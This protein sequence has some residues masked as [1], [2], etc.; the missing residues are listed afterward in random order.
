[1]FNIMKVLKFG[2]SSVANAENIKKV[3]DII[4]NSIKKDK[5]SIVVVSALGGVTDNLI[6]LAHLASKGDR[7]YRKLMK[8]IFEQ[9]DFVV[10]KLVSKKIQSLIL[11]KIKEKYDEL[12]DALRG[13][14]LLGELSARSLDKIISYGEQLSS[15]IICEAI[16]DKGIDCNF[17]DARELIK[18]D[19]NFGSAQ[20]DIEKTCKLLSGYFKKYNGLSIMGGFISS[21]TD[22]IT[23]TLGRGGSDYTASLVGAALDAHI[24]EIWT[25]VD[26]VLTADP[27][28][29]PHAFLLAQISYEEAG[30][31]AHF[32]AK[33]IHP[34]T[35]KP[36]RFKGIP[37]DI[38]NTFNPTA[39]GTRICKDTLKQNFAIRAISSLSNVSLL[40]IQSNNGRVIGEIAAKIFHSLSRSDVEILLITQASH[41]QSLSIAVPEDQVQRAKEGIEREFELELQAKYISPISIKNKLSIV[42]IVGRHMQGVPGISGKLFS[43]LGKSDINVV[44]I[45]QGSSE[46]NISIVIDSQDEKKALGEIHKAFFETQDNSIHVFL[47][48]T[49]LI[50][51]TLLR[52]IKESKLPVRLC[53]ISNSQ[54]MIINESGILLQD[55]ETSLG[56]GQQNDLSDFIS[57]MINLNL[58]HTVFVDCTASE[59][60]VSFYENILKSGVA[61]VTPNKK[62]NSNSLLKYKRLKQLSKERYT[63]FFYETNV[64]A[65]LP[66]IRTIQD[67]VASG[68]Q[69]IKIEAILSGTLSYIFNTFSRA[70]K[71]FSSIVREAQEN[72]YTEPDPRDDLNGKDFARKMLIL[73]RE[74]GMP[75]ELSNVHVETLLSDECMQAESITEFYNKLKEMDSIFKRQRDK[76]QACNKVLRY[77]GVLEK[78]KSKIM[79]KEVD[80][81]SPFYSLEGSDNLISITTKRY[82]T[83]PLVIRGPGAG[84]EVTAGG[85][86]ADIIH[87]LPNQNIY[88]QAHK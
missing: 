81:T 14:Y 46:L 52:Q 87:C 50:G 33:V 11:V 68:D 58:P 71:A 67:L 24:I 34:K 57:N 44:A 19:D 65:A 31:L 54:R 60:A 88:E 26:G 37:I 41:E 73:G 77:I 28:K 22:G 66:I 85:V 4:Q 17:V 53:G 9:H 36:A 18:T 86:L 27:R 55:W 2:G 82:C 12:S 75:M 42:A 15:Y 35:M 74:I 25:D 43:T 59:D 16:R 80:S 69:I 5:Q 70:N 20:V 63:P 13:I 64:G 47:V 45:A 83:T 21:S 56:G 29:V 78:D 10:R 84:A 51:S 8:E 32:G 79:L 6:N 39:P 1:M 7:T 30:E 23:T 38:K 48:G 72:G 3:I 49:G 40:H 61:I 62:A 76:V